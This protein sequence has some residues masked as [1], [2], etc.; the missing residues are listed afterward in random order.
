MGGAAI[1]FDNFD[2]P[3]H[4]DLDIPP[5]G[6]ARVKKSGVLKNIETATQNKI[7]FCKIKFPF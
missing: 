6:K 3:H 1:N 2:H 5:T 7:I 4:C